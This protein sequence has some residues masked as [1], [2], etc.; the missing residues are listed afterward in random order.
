MGS[1]LGNALSAIV[2]MFMAMII[3]FA[4]GWELA[5]LNMIAIPII[6]LAVYFQIREHKVSH[7][8]QAELMENIV[9]L[10]TRTI[11]EIWSVQTLSRALDVCMKFE[12][13]LHPAL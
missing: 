4:F 9:R 1:R 8:N 13:F 6:C 5:L 12:N 7:S 3:S 11:Q 10:S 2:S